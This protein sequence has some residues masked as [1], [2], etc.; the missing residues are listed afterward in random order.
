MSRTRVLCVDD[1]PHVLDGL[2]ANLR[3]HFDVT[4]ATGSVAGIAVLKTQ[5]P[6]AIVLSDMRMPL[7]NGATF[8][9]RVREAAPF[10]IRL[11]LTG[12]ADLPSAV[13]AVNEGQIFRFLLK[14]CRPEALL[15][16]V[17]EA[18]EQYRAL[19]TERVL[20][21][22]TLRGAITL[23]T[24]IL[25]LTNPEIYGEA[26]RIKLRMAE[27]ATMLGYR[28]TW[29]FEIAA[30]LSQIG[31]VTLPPRTVSKIQLGMPLAVDERIAVERMPSV[32]DQLLA[33]IPRL[34]EVREILRYR[35][36]RYDG[37][38]L[39][40]DQPAGEDLPL[41]ARLFK[42]VHDLDVLE[43]GGMSFGR[44]LAELRTRDGWYDPAM[45]EALAPQAKQIKLPE[46][47][48]AR[49]VD[50]ALGM[51]FAEDV[52]S[53]AGALL[54]ARGY[55]VTE[56]LLARLK[57]SANELGIREPFKVLVPA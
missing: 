29:Q 50:L 21:E 41:G 49:L 4:T 38:D 44:A 56:S 51:V 13:E 28:E 2:K 26:M 18:A 40:L 31:Y 52:K 54:I 37:R 8:L 12:E 11:L 19:S 35:D 3:R 22:Q 25:S 45:L 17:S 10:T 46:V 5:G 39:G 36:C 42:L 9:K 57:G 53:E 48:E 16:A 6:F 1:E 43:G 14:P 55:P 27:V 32:V 23:L 20:L 7:M 33:H 47:R 24:E 34:E 30:M 15:A